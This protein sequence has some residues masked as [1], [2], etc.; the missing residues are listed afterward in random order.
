MLDF[1][2]FACKEGTKILRDAMER[3]LEKLNDKLFKERDYDFSV[4]GKRSRTLPST[5]GDLKF[6]RRIYVDKHGNS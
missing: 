3:S 2:E 6:N 5:L 4:K 1:K